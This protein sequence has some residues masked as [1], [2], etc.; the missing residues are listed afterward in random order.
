MASHFPT[1]VLQLVLATCAALLAFN[2]AQ[3]R[4][5]QI[6]ITQRT[7]P[8]FNGQAFGTVGAYEQ[9]RGS[10]NGEIDPNDRRNA[11]ITDIQLA[12]RNARGNVEYTATFTIVKPIDMSKAS[13]VMVYEVV[14]RGNHLLGGPSAFLNVG[15]F[16]GTNG[17][18]GD[19]FFY[20]QG[21]VLLW[22]GWQ[23]DILPS[24]VPPTSTQ[25]SVA[26][27]IAHNPDGSTV[28]SPVFSDFINLPPNT[29]TQQLA[30]TSS[31]SDLGT[32]GVTSR[33]PLTLDTSQATLISATSETQTGVLSGAVNIPG[34]D[35]AFAD[36]RTV[37]FPGTVDP[38]RIC[39]RN[40]F[41]RALLYRLVYTAKDPLVLGVGMAAMRDVA[42]FFRYSIV[43]DVGTANPIANTVPHV[44]GYGISQSGRYMKTFLNLGFNEDEQGR[45]VW[46]AADAD[47]GG[48]M[49]QFNIRFANQGLISNLYDPGIEAPL[50]WADYNDVVRGR[51]VTGILHRCTQ[52]N[53]CPLVFET[54]GGAEFWYGRAGVGISG[55][56][57]TDDIA[58]PANVRRYYM[59]GTT[60]AGGGGGFMLPQPAVNNCQL[61]SN[62]MPERETLRALYV[63]LKT[64]LVQ[65]VEPPASAYPRT[66]DGTLV[67]ATKAAMGYPTI[68]NSPSPDGVINSLLDYDFGPQ[69]RY[70]DESGV[71]T[72]AVPPVK[73][74]IPTLASKVDA[75]G[76]EVAGIRA[77][78]LQVP[79]GTYT[80]WNPYASGPLLGQEC[81]LS[82]GY[83]PFARTRADR[84]ASG[85]P[86]LSVEERYGTSGNYHF[87]V[88]VAAKRLIAQRYLLP[89]D[90]ARLT[91]Q[92]LQDISTLLPP[93]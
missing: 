49:G 43:D 3:A 42:S 6:T 55:T 2:A 5:T 48:A 11:L 39:L 29:N 36:C 66:S 14:N 57:G 33:P 88:A 17:D 81:T 20:N 31:Y 50:W 76:N 53:T 7:T 16:P 19:G 35:W 32:Q 60:H 24:Q 15:G 62:P 1:R 45:K 59:T 87:A 86:R 12:P 56:T 85:D 9:I 74:V 61:L 73:Q 83:I 54:Y 28:S 65:G 44:I 51:G 22:S 34:T 8:L 69:F 79:L 40:G 89:A 72:N 26:V 77:V 75:D 80:G 18:P 78:L 4:V 41:N 21:D 25:E 58:L 10:A 90:G 68:P 82:G 46:D 84:L 37:P 47:I 67:P 70:S 92:A 38:T 71:I 13:G 93:R 63:A 30:R 91:A 64:W 23:G 27:P 52:T